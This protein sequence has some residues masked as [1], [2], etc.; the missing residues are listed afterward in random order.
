MRVFRGCK[1][2]YQVCI[3]GVIWVSIRGLQ[4]VCDLLGAGLS[5]VCVCV[6]V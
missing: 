4:L 6:C 2:G 5:R 1:G 3:R